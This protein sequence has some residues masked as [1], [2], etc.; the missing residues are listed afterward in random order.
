M[1]DTPLM[2]KITQTRRKRPHQTTGERIARLRLAEGWSQRQLAELADLST[3]TVSH[4]EQGC[5]IYAHTLDRL[6][7]ALCV[8]MTYLWSGK[9]D[10][11]R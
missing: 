4:A 6:S 3:Y 10:W 9:E 7:K 1:G 5:E 8:S 11:Q 2:V